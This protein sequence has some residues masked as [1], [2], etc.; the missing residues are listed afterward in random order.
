MLTQLPVM[1]YTS[2]SVTTPPPPSWTYTPIELLSWIRLP[3]AS[4][5]PPE[6]ISIPATALPKMS[7]PT[8]L[9][10]PSSHTSIPETLPSRTCEKNE[11]T[12]ERIDKVRRR[13]ETE[14]AAEQGGG[15]KTERPLLL[16]VRL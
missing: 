12:M 3:V 8:S 1:P 15:T 4:G 2:L 14:A 13:C 11:R 10:T 5:W 9:P 16:S 6:W 7:L